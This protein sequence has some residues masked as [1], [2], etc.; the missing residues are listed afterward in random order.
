[1]SAKGIAVIG[2]SEIATGFRLVGIADS[3]SLTGEEAA[4]KL[5]K[6]VEEKTHS[7]IIVSESVK[8]FLGRDLIHLEVITD[9]LVVFLPLP[10]G[11]DE[12]SVGALAKRVL[13]V[14]IGV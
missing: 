4:S 14:D 6:L 3:F 10:G 1:M 13:G 12:E 2:E 8:N 9:P 5:L 7:L 11:R